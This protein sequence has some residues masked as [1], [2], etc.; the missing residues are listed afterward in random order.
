MN[1]ASLQSMMQLFS[2][3]TLVDQS[4]EARHRREFDAG[5]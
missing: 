2:L 3:N 1:A 5:K 4:I